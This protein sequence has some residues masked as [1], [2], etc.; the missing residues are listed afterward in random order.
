MHRGGGLTARLALAAAVALDLAGWACV[1]Q[2][3]WRLAQLVF[4]AG[5]CFVA[6]A[7]AGGLSR[8]R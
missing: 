1:A 2:G 7:V 3:A 4:L 8:R 5:I 6:V